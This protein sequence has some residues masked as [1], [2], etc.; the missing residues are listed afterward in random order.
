MYQYVVGFAYLIIGLFVYFRRGS[1]QKAQHFYIFCLASL[2]VLCFH[3]TGKLNTFDKVIYYGNVVAG[4]LA[5]TLFLHFC[6]TFPEPRKWFRQPRP[7]GAAVRAG[8]PAVPGV[9][10]ALQFGRA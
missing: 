9:S 5:P 6:L 3:Y 8:A 4:L 1:A 10:S 7:D 2:S